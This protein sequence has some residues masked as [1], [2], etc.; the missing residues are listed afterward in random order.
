MIFDKPERTGSNITIKAIN[1]S[2]SCTKKGVKSPDKTD[3]TKLKATR[4]LK[5][6]T[7][8]SLLYNSKIAVT[9]NDD[10][11]NIFTGRNISVLDDIL[12]LISKYE[13]EYQNILKYILMS[14][15]HLCKIT[16]KHSNSQW[17]LWI[18]K[19]DCVEKIS[20]I[21]TQK[22]QKIL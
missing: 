1:Y 8:T 15:L 4:K 16:D 17:P 5:N 12:S 3:Y 18:P 20:L 19:T 7:S 21:F 2:C 22:N 9:E 11:K 10:I 6:V 14:I 13:P